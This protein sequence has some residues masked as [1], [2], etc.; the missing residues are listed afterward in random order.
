MLSKCCCCIPLRV[1]C[2]ILSIMGI[3]GGIICLAYSE[4]NI[5]FVSEGV[6]WIIADTFLFFGS[7]LMHRK[8][9]LVAL[10]FEILA[11]IDT[12]VILVFSSISI[13][14]VYPEL[15]NNCANMGNDI[16]NFK[17]DCDMTKSSYL[18]IM[19]G[20]ACVE[21]TLNL[22]F[23]FCIYSFYKSLQIPIENLT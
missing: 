8:T 12:I 22:Y 14:T 4:G 1:G 10:V 16:E 3:V 9:I 21:L 23:W 17:I 15:S 2:F 18:Q 19:V 11:M 13:E 7:L 20:S 6:W 5:L